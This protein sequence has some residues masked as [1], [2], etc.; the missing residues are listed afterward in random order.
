MN[1]NVSYNDAGRHPKSGVTFCWENQ[2]CVVQGDRPQCR[3][4]SDTVL[5]YHAQVVQFSNSLW[6]NII[7]QNVSCGEGK[8]VNDS[9]TLGNTV[10]ALVRESDPP[11]FEV[12][13][14]SFQLTLACQTHSHACS[15]K[16]FNHQSPFSLFMQCLS[17]TWGKG[18]EKSTSAKHFFFFWAQTQ[19]S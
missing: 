4:A 14:A 15:I 18:D 12:Y 16:C 1:A 11:N 8:F 7:K 3:P 6:V 17:V 19:E 2:S 5:C 10:T 13:P 9:G